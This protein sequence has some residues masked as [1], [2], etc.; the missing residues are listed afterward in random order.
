MLRVS[1]D[2]LDSEPY[3]PMLYQGKRFTG[4]AEDRLPDGTMNSATPY[5]NGWQEGP[6]YEWYPDGTLKAVGY[7]HK[8]IP[9]GV[10]C[11]WRPDGTLAREIE[12]TD[13]GRILRRRGFDRKGNVCWE[14]GG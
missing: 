12:F 11:T 9:V 8:D 5:V 2:D 13:G 3:G 6:D 4:V 1:E 7:Y 14:D 10:H